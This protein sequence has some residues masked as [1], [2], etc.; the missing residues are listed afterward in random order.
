MTAMLNRILI[1]FCIISCSV[2][3]AQESINLKLQDP[4]ESKPKGV[5]NGHTFITNSIVRDPF[6]KSYLKSGLG[7]GQTIDYEVPAVEVN[8]EEIL[9]LKGNL[10]FATLNFE[11]QQALRDWLA[12]YGRF[13]LITRIGDEPQALIAQGV[14][15]STGFQLGWLGKLLRS[16]QMQLSTFLYL[17]NTSATTIDLL[18]F[19]Q[20]VIDSGKVVPSNTLVESTPVTTVN[21]GLS[22]AYAFNRTFGLTANFEFG[23]GSSLDREEENKWTTAWG[24]SFDCDFKPKY[25]VPV[26][27]LFAYQN[28][29]YDNTQIVNGLPIQFLFQLNYTGREDFE[30]GVALNYQTFKESTYDTKLQFVNLGTIFKYYF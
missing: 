6:I 26:G 25:S 22:Y 9:A 10:I 15:L 13:S 16:R 8:G 17:N 3:F 27:L 21:A 2:C 1:L 19:V 12:F 5:L 23:Y 28:S 24:V 14:N 30:F 29:N 20:G 18:S 7:I 11:Y 4:D